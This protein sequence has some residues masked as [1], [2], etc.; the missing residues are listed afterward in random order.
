M[1]ISEGQ[2]KKKFDS[3]TIAN[4]NLFAK[5]VLYCESGALVILYFLDSDIETVFTRNDMQSMF[6]F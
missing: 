2:L 4:R 6:S 3:K 1:I 5:I